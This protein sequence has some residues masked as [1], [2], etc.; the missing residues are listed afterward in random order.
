[1]RPTPWLKAL[2][3]NIRAVLADSSGSIASSNGGQIPRE[4]TVLGWVKSIRVHKKVAFAVLSDG[5]GPPIQAVFRDP[6]AL[7]E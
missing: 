1:M 7:A 4:V 5:S 3:P 6:A 2:S